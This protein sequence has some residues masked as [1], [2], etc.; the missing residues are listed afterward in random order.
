MLLPKKPPNT[1]QYWLRHTAGGVMLT[2]PITA[3]M[4]AGIT[5]P[6]VPTCTGSAGPRRCRVANE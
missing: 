2:A 5:G 6:L 1:G 3:P 4:S